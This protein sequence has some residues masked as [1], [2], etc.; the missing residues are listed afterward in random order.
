MLTY[1]LSCICKNGWT[2]DRCERDI[3]ECEIG[4]GQ[5][6]HQCCN[7]VGS[8]KCSCPQGWILLDDE[9]T[10]SDIDECQER[11]GGCAHQCHNVDG[12]YQCSCDVGY[13]LHNDQRSCL[14]VN[15]CARG[16]ACLI[17][18]EDLLSTYFSD[19]ILKCQRK[20]MAIALKSVL[21]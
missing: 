14:P 1:L 18:D 15:R 17:N 19:M 11:N 8:Y 7:L 6:S 2:G 10:C 3:N 13:K 20:I 16:K 9:R 12:G 21:C 4:N 5:C